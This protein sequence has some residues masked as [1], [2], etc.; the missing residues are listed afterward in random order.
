MLERVA[1]RRTRRRIQP[2]DV[3][4]FVL[5]SGNVERVIGRLAVNR[6]G[7]WAMLLAIFLLVPMAQKLPAQA[8]VLITPL[9]EPD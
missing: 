4:A 5:E 6:V 3:D 9:R 7:D 8:I 1:E 2:L